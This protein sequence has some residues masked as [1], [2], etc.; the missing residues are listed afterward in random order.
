MGDGY[1]DDKN[2]VNP[3]FNRR[4]TDGMSVSA[5]SKG[6]RMARMVLQNGTSRAMVR[7]G[8]EMGWV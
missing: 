2:R 1:N 6:K 4:R 3:I 5:G 7:G 8:T